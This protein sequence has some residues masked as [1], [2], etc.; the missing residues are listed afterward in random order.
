MKSVMLVLGL[1]A[2]GLPQGNEVRIKPSARAANIEAAVIVAQT[3]VCG[4]QPSTISC[5]CVLRRRRMFEE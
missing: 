1:V 4:S 2:V 3:T 5:T